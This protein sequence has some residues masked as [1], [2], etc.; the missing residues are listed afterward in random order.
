[1]HKKSS[2]DPDQFK[3]LDVLVSGTLQRHNYWAL[4]ENL[5]NKKLSKVL[6]GLATGLPLE[7][8]AIELGPKSFY[9]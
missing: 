9:L 2:Q 5:N 8:L 1:M 4:S 7:E 3:T 6:R